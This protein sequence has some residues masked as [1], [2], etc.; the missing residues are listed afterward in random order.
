MRTGLFASV[1]LG[2]QAFNYAL[3]FN[4]NI[5]AWNTAAMTTIAS[6]CAHCFTNSSS[7]IM[8]TIDSTEVL[9][10]FAPAQLPQLRR[11]SMVERQHIAPHALGPL[12]CCVH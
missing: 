4:A 7:M 1:W 9:S 8:C 12:A 10:G 11:I 5:A 3:A 6:V 2:S